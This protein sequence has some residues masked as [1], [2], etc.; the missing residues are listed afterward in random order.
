MVASWLL[1]DTL[2]EAFGTRPTEPSDLIL[3]GGHPALAAGDVAAAALW[4]VSAVLFT[5]TAQRTGDR[6]T[7]WLGVAC[8]LS[9]VSS[10]N[11]ALVPTH[12]T[13]LL[14]LG[15]YFFLAAVVML[16]VAAARAIGA[17]EAAR[18]DG[19]L[20]AERRRIA[21]E[22]HDGVTQEL[23]HIATQAQLITLTD[24]R[25]QADRALHRIQESIDRA[26]D[27]SRCAIQELSG[28]VD[29]PLSSAIALTANVVGNSAGARLEL[30]MD[31]SVEVDPDVRS[32]LLSITRDA[33]SHAVRTCGA[34]NVRID[35]WDEGSVGLRITD[36][37]RGAPPEAGE[38]ATSSLLS[39]RERADAV[40][41][42]V[43]V[44]TTKGAGRSL[45][46]VVP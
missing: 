19:A 12:F 13:E 39:I 18:L 40:R 8:V 42:R 43:T 4:A 31:D 22:M 35:L 41:G 3:L 44:S 11:Y 14:Y 24:D 30:H 33:V 37:G 21:R 10:V 23:A 7:R 32:A 34:E 27:Q 20:Y 2:P 1:R 15:D 36:D 17:A 16:L 6:L 28:P 46:V 25:A 29:E 9:A 45:E 38:D 5:R 26:L